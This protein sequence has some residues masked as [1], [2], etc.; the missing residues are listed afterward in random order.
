MPTAR[1]L[2]AA[3]VLPALAAGV[4]AGSA[5]AGPADRTLTLAMPLEPPHLDPTAGA[6]AAI[7]E[8]V[9]QNIFESLTRIDENGAVVPGLATSWDVSPDGLAYTFRLRDGVRYSD[10]TTFDSADVKY[11]LDRARA[12]DSVNAQ[13]AYF[14]AIDTVETPDPGTVV[15]RLSH[16][17]GQFL[18]NMGS[19]D[20]AILAPETAADAGT[21]P[22]GTGPF[23]LDRWVQGDRVEL[24]RNP[25]YSGPDQV[26]LDRVVIRIV[27]DPA[28]QVAS[29]L[30]GDVDAYPNFGAPEA[31]GQFEGEPRLVVDIGTTEGET[32]LGLN[33]RKAPFD[34]LRVR[35]ALASAIDKQAVIDIA[36]FGY[37]TPIGSHFAPHN[38][39]YVDL[40]GTYPYDVARARALLAEAGYPDG[41]EA[42]LA[43]PPPSY[44]RRGGEVVQA[45]LAE[46][47]VR[48]ELVPM[49]W[50]Q[51]LEQVFTNH[52]FD[53]TIV[54]HT[55]PYDIGIYARGDD[56]YF[57]YVNPEFDDVIARV[58]A[59]TNEAQ[60]AELYGEAQ[61]ILARD[62]P[63][64]FL[65]QLPK[66]GVHDARLRG[67][68][69]N[70]PVQANDVTG[71]AWTE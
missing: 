18:F 48:V 57:G 47:G 20:A 14:E 42:T 62:V 22:V 17:D 40:S 23:M 52:D 15:V 31:L 34:D 56:Y 4:L 5:L 53:M 36:Y 6:A 41:F 49:E 26:G 70:S 68:W 58:N 39:A 11:S 51:W 7:D 3:L 44:A 60:R 13:K 8:V 35:Q 59:S 30:S 12:P 21:R 1:L 16:P 71:V 67:L 43:L 64:V 50:A 10:G 69:R 46:I 33:N 27:A 28:A 29:I 2:L 61:R 9:Y 63:A 55:E 54:S 37:G 65:F 24:V 19:G 66:L 25:G 45:Q 38:A 32:I